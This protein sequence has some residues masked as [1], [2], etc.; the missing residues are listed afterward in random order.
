M[1][2]NNTVLEHYSKRIASSNDVNKSCLWFSMLFVEIQI[3]IYSLLRFDDLIKCNKVCKGWKTLL[4]S[5]A[6]SVL[7]KRINYADRFDDHISSHRFNSRIIATAMHINYVD[8]IEQISISGEC[9]NLCTAMSL[10]KAFSARP[11]DR[12]FRLNIRIKMVSLLCSPSAILN[13]I[14]KFCKILVIEVSSYWLIKDYYMSSLKS[15]IRASRDH[16]EKVALMETYLHAI[17]ESDNENVRDY[18]RNVV[19][20][21]FLDFR[22]LRGFFTDL[23][24]DDEFYRYFDI[25]FEL[26]QLCVVRFFFLLSI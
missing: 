8:N 24:V 23:K 11:A 15:Y 16:R 5:P 6:A 22:G 1:K 19:R 18:I 10:D 9:I 3:H 21:L 25:P 2:N 12:Q 14:F 20:E 13:V 17:G 4:M 26:K 7:F